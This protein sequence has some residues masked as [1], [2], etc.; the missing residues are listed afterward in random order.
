MLML[1]IHIIFI[2]PFKRAEERRDRVLGVF[3]EDGTELFFLGGVRNPASDRAI[4]SF[5]MIVRRDVIS[6]TSS[7]VLIGGI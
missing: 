2:Y 5:F 3:G 4:R 6:A 1:A 7:A